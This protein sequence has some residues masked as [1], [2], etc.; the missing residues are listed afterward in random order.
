MGYYNQEIEK[1]ATRRWKRDIGSL[2][3]ANY[4]RLV[5]SG[6]LNHRKQIDGMNE[7]SDIILKK[8]NGIY[9]L[10]GSLAE[11]IALGGY[12][13]IETGKNKGMIAGRIKGGDKGFVLIKG[14]KPQ[15]VA[16]ALREPTRNSAL[17]ELQGMGYSSYTPDNPK[18]KATVRIGSWTKDI[19]PNREQTLL[20]SLDPSER[21]EA[22]KKFDQLRVL[23]KK[24]RENSNKTEQEYL[25]AI[26]KR[27][28]VDEVRTKRKLLRA[29]KSKN[30]F[31]HNSP[32]ILFR[33]SV[34][35]ANS[36]SKVRNTLSSSR[37]VTGELNNMAENGL[38][39][40]KKGTLNKSKMR[41]FI[42][43]ASRS[44]GRDGQPF[45]KTKSSEIFR[46]VKNSPVMSKL[47]EIAADFKIE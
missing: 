7:G 46:K 16:N 2:S 3:D 14:E 44:V 33:E 31:S 28:E 37:E 1:L 21:E 24:V 15:E 26:S 29:K 42:N 11:D 38:K 25:E 18:E 47:Q 40:A 8:N 13:K 43:R 27:H 4:N 45:Q 6:V 5:S 22:K 30:Y 34:N 9:D 32:E 23:R 12:G 35:A 20:N 10:D 41:K 19:S 39:Y 17:K 36:P